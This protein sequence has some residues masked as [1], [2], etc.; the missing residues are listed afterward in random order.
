MMPTAR[1]A[2]L[3]LLGVLLL[4]VA[5]PSPRPILLW[6]IAS[7]PDAL[8]PAM[9]IGGLCTLPGLALLRLLCPLPA[10]P[11]GSRL[12]LAST[13]SV[14][15]P[16]LLLLLTAPLG[17][18]WQPFTLWLY[19]L[20]SAAVVFA[21]ARSAS[22]PRPVWQS[23]RLT[24]SDTVLLIVV[25]AALLVRLYVVRDLPTGLF[26]DSYHHTM[27]AQLLVDN[28][29]LFQ[30]WQPYAPLT[31][32][33]YHFGL[34]ANVAFVHWLTG[35]P[36]TTALLITGQVLNTLVVFGLA[37]LVA[38]LAQFAPRLRAA[39]WV[40]VWA[41]LLAG[42][43][44]TIPMHFVV[45]G[46][47]TQL[48]GQ[49]V[50]LAA[51]CIWLVLAHHSQQ[52]LHAHPAHSWRD[53]RDWLRLVLAGWRVMLLA[54]ILSAAMVLTHYRVTVFTAAMIVSSLVA[55][56]LV[57]RSV[58]LG[59]VLAAQ[60]TL[61]GSG[62]LLLVAAWLHNIFQKGYLLRNTQ[63]FVAGQVGLDRL[64]QT[65]SI[66]SIDPLYLPRLLLAL[67]VLGLLI[68][69]W[70]RVW[71]IVLLAVWALLIVLSMVPRAVGLPG[72]GAIDGL[73]AFGTLFIALVP[74][75]A[76]ALVHVHCGVTQAS[77]GRW[78]TV[79]VPRISTGIAVAALGVVL[80]GGLPHQAQIIPRGTATYGN[81]QL[82]TS[83]DMRAMDWIAANTAP[84]SR[85][86]V[87]SFPAYGGTMLAGS[88][89]GWWLP[90]LAHRAS[91][92]PPI[93][94]GSEAA[95][96]PDFLQQVNA[97]AVALRGKPLTDTAPLLIDATTPEALATLRAAGVS[98]VYIGAT[99]APV[100]TAIDQLDISR[101]Q[102]SSA[103]EIVYD[104]EGV[105][106][107]RLSSK[108]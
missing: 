8:L 58:Q 26:G 43:V 95:D 78:P 32:M 106:I 80:L 77:T 42:F 46:R 13:I 49:I 105:L 50:L 60:A 37:A 54:A 45:W 22:P 3:G 29:G 4:A 20:F 88:D 2:V 5:L 104:Q 14:A 7:L 90:L 6:G 92:L 1:R 73:T 51:V 65:A 98:H 87:N 31:T 93:T 18:L 47:Y 59:L 63:A 21:P 101:L 56:V 69:L 41:V 64:E 107:F 36:V 72:T 28:G 83:A 76:Y 30:S 94:Y 40:G 89:A 68:A 91:T 34:H 66:P 55:V 86:L 23:V 70:Q 61:V 44:T 99:S 9:L 79:P 53:W 25:V 97:L 19:L 71:P 12:A 82:V 103:Y 15:L 10:W 108:P 33:T 52:L 74:L 102:A 17:G 75:A 39:A 24:P 81:S 67:A 35:M 48:A 85:F 11:V 96:S 38:A 57:V 16:P 100:A 27:I 84:E 62:A